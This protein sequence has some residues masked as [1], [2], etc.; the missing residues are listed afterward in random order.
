MCGLR[1]GSIGGIKRWPAFV[2]SPGH[3]R[4]WTASSTLRKNRSHL[5]DGLAHSSKASGSCTSGSLRFTNRWAHMPCVPQ[6]YRPVKS[7]LQP[8]M[9]RL[10]PIFMHR[11]TTR[12]DGLFARLMYGVQKSVSIYSVLILVC[13]IRH[14][15][16]GGGA[17]GWRHIRENTTRTTLDLRGACPSPGRCSQPLSHRG[18]SSRYE[19]ELISCRNACIKAGLVQL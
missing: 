7:T 14:Q 9:D 15:P 8:N 12:L 4:S 16:G 1:R 18:P 11:R 3:F 5:Y 10:H 13:R 17:C 2:W 6:K 19:N